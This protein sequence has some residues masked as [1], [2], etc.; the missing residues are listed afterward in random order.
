MMFSVS[1]T[2]KVEGLNVPDSSTSG[3]RQALLNTSLPKV[4]K[5]KEFLGCA[6]E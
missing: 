2:A 6:T 1:W 5:G 4:W 3:A